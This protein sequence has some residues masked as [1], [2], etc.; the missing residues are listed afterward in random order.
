MA[1]EDLI[2]V[3]DAHGLIEDPP[4]GVW[5]IKMMKSG[6]I[7]PSKQI[8][9]LAAHAG[10]EVM[11]GCNDE[12]RVSI[13]AALHT[14]FSC[15]ATRYLDLDGSFDIARDICEGGFLLENGKLR[16]TGAPGLGVRLL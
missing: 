14:A 1:D 2:S 7:T 3:K 8:A 10:I 4:Y 12:S 15:S 16:L 5:N 6:G 9:A 11:W 13:A